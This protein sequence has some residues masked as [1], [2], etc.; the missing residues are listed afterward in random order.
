MVQIRKSIVSTL[1]LHLSYER[2]ANA[3]LPVAKCWSRGFRR[4][5]GHS[6]LADG[7]SDG[8]ATATNLLHPFRSWDALG[9]QAWPF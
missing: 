6:L 2:A 4:V 9:G 7:S 5:T 1:S 8:N 3:E